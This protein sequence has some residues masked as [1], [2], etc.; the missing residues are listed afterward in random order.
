MAV[1]INPGGWIDIEERA[2][3]GSPSTNVGRLYVADNGGTTTLYF[4]D[5]AGTVTALAAAGGVTLD[6]AYDQGGA[7][8]GKAVTVDSG[9]IALSNAG[10]NN[11]GLLTVN[12]SPSGAQSG[13][14]VT[15]T[16]GA[17]CSG[18]CIQ[19]AN[20]GSGKDLA[21]TG[22]TWS[23]SAAGAAVLAALTA[24]GVI[25]LSGGVLAGAS[26]LVFEGN[27]ADA[28]ETT[29]AITDPT[30]DRTI[31]IPDATG[32]V[33]LRATATH[34]YGGGATAWTLSAAEAACSFLSVSNANA[35]CTMQISSAMAGATWLV[36]NGSGQTLTF[37]VSGATG[38]TL[39][40]GKY[41]FYACHAT[42]IVEIFEQA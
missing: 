3:P 39:A 20:S 14:L 11:N 18:D 2:A 12:K 21:G 6:G 19:F 25:D 9:A 16:A 31:T 34:D 28:Y 37:K 22:G 42:D 29:I 10:A 5:S 24:T 35:G 41:G 36:Y 26:P 17:N 27:T 15:I 8:S 40:N 4:K 33:R 23:I 13:D 7:G 1:K 32:T 30:A 38:A